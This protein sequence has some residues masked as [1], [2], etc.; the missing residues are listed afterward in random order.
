MPRHRWKLTAPYDAAWMFPQTHACV[1]CGLIRWNEWG[2]THY[3]EPV[4]SPDKRPRAWEHAPSCPYPKSP[5]VIEDYQ[6]SE[7]AY[8]LTHGHVD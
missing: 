1:N 3:Y 4:S 6:L 5:P 7:R 2:D 8:L